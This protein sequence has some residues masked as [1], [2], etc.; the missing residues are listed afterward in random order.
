MAR[1]DFGQVGALKLL[2][3]SHYRPSQVSHY[4]SQDQRIHPTQSICSFNKFILACP[5]L[6]I[7][8]GYASGIHE[9]TLTW[10]MLNVKFTIDVV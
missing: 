9:A 4:T 10:N 1:E 5:P 8:N 7:C 6:V 2:A 3:S